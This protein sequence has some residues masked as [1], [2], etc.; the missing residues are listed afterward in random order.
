MTVEYWSPEELE[1]YHDHPEVFIRRGM[2]IRSRVIRE[3]FTDLFKRIIS[4]FN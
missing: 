3:L 4:L 1:E 2:A